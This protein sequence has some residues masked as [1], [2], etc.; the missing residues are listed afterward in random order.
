MKHGNRTYLR[1]FG[2]AEKLV[3]MSGPVELVNAY[4]HDLSS[5]WLDGAARHLNKKRIGGSLHNGLLIIYI[6]HDRFLPRNP[7]SYGSMVYIRPS[8]A[9]TS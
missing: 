8:R 2:A 5:G 4:V 7:R 3:G 1:L 9:F 6:L